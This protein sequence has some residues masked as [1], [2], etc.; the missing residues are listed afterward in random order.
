M[1]SAAVH[2]VISRRFIQQAGEE[3]D[4]GDLLQ[5]SEKAWGAVAHQ[6]K[7]IAI[8]RNWPHGSHWHFGRM[9]DL[10]G[11]ETNN[12][13]ELRLL[14]AEADSLHA[15]FYNAFMPESKIREC[16]ENVKVLL[17]TLEETA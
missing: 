14:M 11:A 8:Q 13:G 3:L 9:I 10:L 4:S 6:L 7:A 16:V 17:D 1:A 5:A 12:V 15:N 2:L